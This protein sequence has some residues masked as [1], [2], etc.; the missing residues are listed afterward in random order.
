MPGVSTGY[1]QNALDEI[2]IQEFAYNNVWL[3]EHRAD[4]RAS[5]LAATAVADALSD[6]RP[7]P[8]LGGW[9]TSLTVPRNCPCSLTT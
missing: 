4:R 7:Q 2:G 3:T 9:G 1:V 5:A 8:P 6:Q